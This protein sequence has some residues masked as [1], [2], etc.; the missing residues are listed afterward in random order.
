MAYLIKLQE[1]EGPLDLLLHL[2]SKSKVR[3]EDISITEITEQYMEALQLMEQF[4]IELASEFLVMASTLMYIKSCSLIPRTAD[5]AEQDDDDPRQEL[6][7]RLLEYKKYKEAAGKMREREAYFSGMFYKLPE[8]LYIDEDKDDLAFDINIDVL[9][10]ALK[11]VL[12]TR[13]SGKKENIAPMIHEIKKD[14][15]TIHE[16]VSLLKFFF[17]QNKRTTFFTIFQS[18]THREDIIATFLALLELIKENFLYVEQ[19]YPYEDIVIKRRDY[20]G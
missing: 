5:P 14:S 4:D 16:K 3:I 9:Q 19:D 13:G 6:I 1:F 11:N 20:C 15:V 18:D 2:I 10:R 12:N 7:T 17:N 8:E